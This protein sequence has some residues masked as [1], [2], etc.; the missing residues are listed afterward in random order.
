MGITDPTRTAT[1]AQLQTSVGR[2]P[3]HILRRY[4]E[5]RNWRLYPKEWV[6]R[7]VPIK[8]RTI[9]DF[10]CGTGEIT[11][12]L[13][14]LGAERVIGLDV[15]PGLLEITNERARLDGV[16]DRVQTVCGYI[17]DLE[18]DA[19]DT[20]IAFAVLHHCH[21]LKNLIPSLMRWLKPGGT[22]VAVEPYCRFPWLERLR[23]ASGVPFDPMD[24]GERKLSAADLDYISRHFSNVQFVPFHLS[25]RLGRFVGS[26]IDRQ[27]RRI[28]YALL[29]TPLSAFAGTMLIVATR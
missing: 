16:A 6:Y 20:V 29:R 24:E 27:L 11:T 17:Q 22:F 7:R 15:T 25:G 8:G 4:R 23:I 5:N 19:V 18:P 14:L 3:E 28:D 26:G 12:Q 1:G 21:P 9:L 10:G 2:T 13:A